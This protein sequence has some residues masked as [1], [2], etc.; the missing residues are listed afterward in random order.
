MAIDPDSKQSNSSGSVNPPNGAELLDAIQHLGTALKIK[1]LQLEALSLETSFDKDLGLDSLSRV[2]FLARIERHFDVSLVQQVFAE[3]DT[4]GDL[5]LEISRAKSTTDLDTT[6]E[7]DP[8]DLSGKGSTPHHA[9]T[10]LDILDW[11]VDSHPDQPHIRFFED[12]GEGE[13]ITYR[14]LKHQASAIACGLQQKGLKPGQAV[15]LMLPTGKSYFFSFFGIL[16]AGG[17]PVPIYPPARINQIEDHLLRHK[18]IL[19]NCGAV[20][21][22]TVPDAKQ[23][24]RLLQPHLPEMHTI[25]T[26]EVVSTIG[27]SPLRP[28]I[29]ADQIAFLQY[30]SGS[31]G[32]PKGVALSHANLLANI[33][34]MG[35]QLD[36]DSNDVFISWLPLYHDMG[37]IGAWLGSLYFSATVVIMSPLEFL[38]KPE[39]WLWAIHRYK[40]TLT[41]A[42]NFAYELCM[43]RVDAETVNRI[44][45]SSL[46]SM[47]NG[48]EPVNPETIEKFMD[49]FQV[50]G[51]KPTAIKPVY[52]LAEC[53]VG[54][55]FPGINRTPLFDNIDRQTFMDKGIAVASNEVEK[56]IR[57]VA[58]GVPLVDHEIRVVDDTDR[59]LPDRY[60]GR[61]Q[62]RGP[63]ATA[64]YYQN[65]E[66]TA[67]L[68]S[69]SWLNT[70]DLAYIADGELYLTGRIKDL[71][72]HAGRNIYPQE[73]ES[74]VSDISG[75]RKGCV[76]V[77]GSTDNEKGTERLVVLAETR[78]TQPVEQDRLRGE[79]N[80]ASI[81]LIGT[82]PD[83]IV[84]AP[85]RSVL[86]TSSG[87][88]RRSAC[89]EI[90]QNNLIGKKSKALGWQI[91]R[92]V[93]SAII[94]QM[95]RSL[96]TLKAYLY[97]IYAWL[98]FLPLAAL[99]WIGVVFTPV[100]NWRR[101]VIRS[102]VKAFALLTGNS[103]EVHGLENLP[104]DGQTRIIIS[105]HCSYLDSA[106]LLLTLP[107]QFSFVAKGELSGQFVAGTM[108]GRM[109]TV[110]VERFERL[111]GVAD[112]DKVTTTA[113]LGKTLL[114][115]P[116]GTFTR[117]P[118]LLPFY[119][120]AFKTAVEAD[121]A[122]V[123]VIIRGTRSIL[124]PDTWFPRRG[125]IHV[126][127]T[128]PIY[129]DDVRATGEHS[130]DHWNTA[131]RL[132]E[133][134]R[135]AMLP[136]TH[137][138]DLSR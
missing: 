94:P 4:P 117:V 38:S 104:D 118:G 114:I 48:A 106:I 120:G 107:V 77:F 82:P 96:V 108:L 1:P 83:E 5:L 16:I 85:P 79:I 65:P 58:C 138:P 46:R 113:R 19:A 8:S 45:L 67:Q 47:F 127:I 3:V 81:A 52:G 125:K 102:T 44:D 133:A 90:Y 36:V 75:I 62:F 95:R 126:T 74:A 56:I 112:A 50:S 121:L 30:T 43:K 9:D 99:T 119:M 22:I 33:R 76:A 68:Y 110:F 6:I 23:V 137:E 11:H 29:N 2:E 17:I 89:R 105:N 59:E 135:E 40:G 69:G 49:H 41:A 55:T 61:L 25:T 100:A 123:P 57:F 12:N 115:F 10:L 15:T 132:K 70:G 28:K 27:S 54:L 124:R 35:A 31:T 14:E 98:M 86:K 97:A 131:Q 136:H 18:R 109:D 72:I 103:V 24:A 130:E 63:S 87:K 116:E 80:S 73:L 88:I 60:Q 129:P 111:K 32:T 7:I 101:S 20:I 64:G 39:R 13:I 37:L 66:Q 122:I 128:A 71:I 92:L 84:L 91:L 93:G 26:P 21:L 78:E 51:L 34:A 53:S 134:S 42:P